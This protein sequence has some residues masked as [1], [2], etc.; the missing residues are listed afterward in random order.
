MSANNILHVSLLYS[1]LEDDSTVFTYGEPRFGGQNDIQAGLSNLN[2]SFPGIIKA[3]STK[4]IFTMSYPKRQPVFIEYEITDTHE[5]G[6]GLRGELFRPIFQNEYFYSHGV[7]LFLNPVFKKENIKA[8]ISVTW[9]KP[10]PFPLFYGFDPENKGQKT[11]YGKADDV[12]FSLITG[13]ANQHVYKMTID[14]STGY[15]VLRE[16]GSGPFNKNLAEDYF[17][18]YFTGIRKFWNATDSNFFSLILHPLLKVNHNISGVAFSNGFIGK[19]KSDTVYNN[20]QLFTLSHEIG[21]HW[22]GHGL[23]MEIKNQWFDEGFNDYIT[24]Y[25]LAVTQL[26]TTDKFQEEMNNVFRLHYSSAVKNTPNDSV[27]LNYWKMGDYNKLPYRRGSIFAFWLDQQIRKTSGNKKNIRSLLLALL[28][29]RKKHQGDYVV[30][31]DDFINTSSKFVQ[32]ELIKDAINKYIISGVPIQ[33][34]ND[35]LLPGFSITYKNEIPVL[36]MTA[37]KKYFFS[38]IN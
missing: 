23:S 25:N 37:Q 18:K 29:L 20:A 14:H 15:V 38:L 35:M 32:K 27:F 1:P 12:M 5:N 9:I 19:Y 21:H 34:T 8:S 16:T 28:Q 13:A 3:D 30:T 10:P 6:T 31:M 33:F 17:K 7:N 2:I 22:L 4:R 36:N 26:I 24:F 11:F